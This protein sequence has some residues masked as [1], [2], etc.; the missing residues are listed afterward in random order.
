M[1]FY[2]KAREPRLSIHDP[3]V[4]PRRLGVLK[5]ATINF[6]AL[7]F[8]FLGLFCYLFASLFQQT[9]HVHNINILFVD[10]DGGSI[11]DAF[12]DAYRQAKGPGFPTLIERPASEYPEP[13]TIND[14]ICNVKYWGSLY[15]SPN[16][17]N[18]LTAA[19]AGGSAASLYNKSE[20]LTL[21]WNEARYPTVIDSAVYN[22][23]Q[24][25]SEGARIAYMNSYGKQAIQAL[26]I[27]D[28]A[29]LAAFSDPWTL[30]SVNLQ[31]TSQGSRA[32]YNTLVIILILIEEF[33]YLGYING[34]Y[35]QFKLYVSVSPHHVAIERHIISGVF[36][37][38]GSLCASG[39]IWAFRHGW[40]VN[41]NQFVVTWMALWLFAHVNFLILD[42]FTIW[43]APSFI[44]MALISWVV[45]NITSIL[46]PLELSPGLYS[47]GYALPAHSI[48]QILIDIW[49]GG[50]N[51]QLDYA[52]PVLF[53]YEIFGLVLSTIG[54]YRRSHYAIIKQ[55]SD[56]KALQEAVTP[57]IIA[58]RQNE[59]AKEKAGTAQDLQESET[60]E[61]EIERGAIQRR[62]TGPTWT[63][64]EEVMEIIRRELSRPRE[65]RP[66]TSR[67]SNGL[68]FDLPFGKKITS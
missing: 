4:R 62:A 34:L 68:C 36:T 25:L 59:L 60:R 31:P 39:A 67:N 52:L 45:L 61:R 41:T 40:H 53:A 65:D 3:A 49:S 46:L 9:T 33:F 26:N 29:A 32:I 13:N 51:P 47:W 24:E 7:Q 55:E 64:R 2:S 14:T 50:C 38:I 37:F 22:P 12:R 30:K 58:Q 35:M 42:I 54:V 66:L 27:S 17:S 8:L 16:S 18:H 48:F 1:G 11:G 5:A 15:V 10:Y 57:A 19:L 20:V 23:M 44:P 21:V 63:G 43:S 28:L 6:L 56:E